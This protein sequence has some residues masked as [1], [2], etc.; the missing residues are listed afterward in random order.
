MTKSFDGHYPIE[1]RDGELERLH[2]Q[3]AAMAPDT[4]IMLDKIGVTQGWSCLDIACGPGG[5]TKL[6]SQRVGTEGRVVGL[7]MNADFLEHARQ[8]AA[9]NTQFVQGDAYDSKLEPG[10][11]D[12]V[13]M[14]FIASTAGEPERLMD[15]AI[16]LTRPGG[17]VV[18]QEPDATSLKCYPPLEAWDDLTQ[19]MMRAFSDVGADLELARKLY[20]MMHQSALT[21]V[22]FRPFIVGVRSGD[23]MTDYLPSTIESIRETILQHQPLSGEDLDALL[24]TCRHHLAQP[25]TSF[26]MYTVAQVWGQRPA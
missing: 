26:T 25:G 24:A 4:E 16:K 1:T 10:S 19:I 21:N 13:H 20:W 7:D 2:T 8:T 22:Q 18:V 17:Y 14:R 11:F 9:S 3:S 15:E 12:F 5:I 6:L 23:P